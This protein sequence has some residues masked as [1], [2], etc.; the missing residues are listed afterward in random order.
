MKVFLLSAYPY[1]SQ[2]NYLVPYVR[3]S[4]A[5]DPF[6][7][8]ALTEDPAEADLI[9][10]T[11]Q[12]PYW[13][14]YY[15]DV[16]RHPI[17]QSYAE[18]CYL[19]HDNYMTIPFMP[20]ITP[21]LERH[22]FD[23]VLT[24]PSGYIVGMIPNNAIQEFG[25]SAEKKYLFSF[26]GASYTHPCRADIF[27]LTHERGRLVDTSQVKVKE[28]SAE[29]TVEFEKSYAAIG[30][31][32]KFILCPRGFGANSYR[33]Y[34]T[35]EMGIPPVIISDEWVP[36]AGPAWED[37]SL[38]LAEAEIA[39][40]PQV[41]VAKE[42]EAERMG[43]L[44]RQAWEEWFAKERQFHYLTEACLRLQATRPQ[45]TVATYLRQGKRFLTSFH[46]RN[47]LRTC[48]HRIVRSISS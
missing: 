22:H 21:L 17:Y 26:V 3:E 48:K 34:E 46:L 44:A 31:A 1:D 42:E 40:L 32:S 8:H 9:I 15:W 30:L 47:V 35:L 39:T 12:R 18:K 37:F 13:D 27:K 45:I 10:F 24:Q 6:Q 23:P 25:L 19:F 41:L 7:V 38:R 43:K 2:D 29:A 16:Y 28:L 36:T 11:E 4:A 5:A 14:P 20:T 33:L